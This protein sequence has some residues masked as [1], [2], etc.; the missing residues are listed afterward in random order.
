[1]Q[2]PKRL[3]AGPEKG[4]NLVP[5]KIKHPQPMIAP[6]ARAQAY[7][8]STDFFSSKRS[9]HSSMP[10]ISISSFEFFILLLHLTSVYLMKYFCQYFMKYF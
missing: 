5:G 7:M 8:G 1:M 6:T 4:K 9:L 2:S 3:A 10:A